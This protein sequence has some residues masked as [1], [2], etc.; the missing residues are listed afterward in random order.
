MNQI[1]VTQS[2]ASPGRNHN[3]IL[4]AAALAIS[5]LSNQGL[6][7][8]M[9]CFYSKNTVDYLCNADS[10]VYYFAPY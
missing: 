1:K 7:Y 9:Y 2:L 5:V 6:H 10:S 4:P 3:L 8:T